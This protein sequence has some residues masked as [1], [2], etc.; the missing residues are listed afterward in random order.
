MTKHLQQQE[1]TIFILLKI[2]TI[3]NNKILHE[4]RGV[5]MKAKPNNEKRR[6]KTGTNLAQVQ[7]TESSKSGQ[8]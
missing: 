8:I 1:C 5:K 3:N 4:R 6:I 2:I 7:H